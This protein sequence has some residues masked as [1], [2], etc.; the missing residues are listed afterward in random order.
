MFAVKHRTWARAEDLTDK[1]RLTSLGP[2][3]VETGS[4]GRG[5]GPVG[6]ECIMFGLL[7][8]E[9]SR[10][11]IEGGAKGLVWSSGEARQVFCSWEGGVGLG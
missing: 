3:A 2:T 11:V 9:L 6:S 5:G 10:D 1:P 4:G 7:L 8:P